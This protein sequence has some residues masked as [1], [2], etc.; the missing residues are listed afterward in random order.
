[1]WA[2]I[3]SKT[4]SVG[5]PI[6]FFFILYALGGGVESDRGRPARTRLR[7]I[8]GVRSQARYKRSA[9]SNCCALTVAKGKVQNT[10]NSR[11]QP[12]LERKGE[13]SCLPSQDLFLEKSH[14]S[15]DFR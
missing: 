8:F 2:M 11:R 7:Q 10:P 12:N 6:I 15:L 14:N 9:S 1:M 5:I 3:G 13:T 4:E